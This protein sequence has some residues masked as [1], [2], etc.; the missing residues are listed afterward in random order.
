MAAT[1]GARR[2]VVGRPATGEER[3]DR[4]DPRRACRAHEKTPPHRPVADKAVGRYRGLNASACAARGP[5]T[6]APS[7][8]TGTPFSTV[9]ATAPR[10]SVPSS[11]DQPHLYR[12]CAA[13]TRVRAVEIDGHE[14]R[15]V[16]LA[17]EAAL[18]DAEQHGGIVRRFLDDLRQSEQP[19][20][21]LI[22]QH[23]QRM[24]HERQA[25]R[26]VEVAAA[27]LLERVRRVIRGDHVDAVFDDGGAQRRSIRGSLDGRIAFDL[28]AE[29]GVARLVEP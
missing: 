27:L 2:R 20:G 8:N 12:T 13:S 1:P 26:R 23:Q 17:D 9:R 29:R 24:L 19:V 5:A 3:R 22:E 25:R 15:V 4:K 28:R 7:R 6:G 11:G 21:V 16:A 18:R 10:R 14:I